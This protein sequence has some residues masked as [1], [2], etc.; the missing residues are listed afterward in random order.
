MDKLAKIITNPDLPGF[1]N[2]LRF[3]INP[4]NQTEFSLER[5]D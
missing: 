5:A 2:T 1:K 4:A 3:K